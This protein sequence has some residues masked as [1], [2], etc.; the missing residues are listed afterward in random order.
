MRPD[1]A[2]TFPAVSAAA[3]RSATPG[4]APEGAAPERCF[5]L[6]PCPRCGEETVIAL[7]LDDLQAFRCGSCEGEFGREELEAIIARWT[8]V[9][10]WLDLAPAKE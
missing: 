6:L 3:V 9:L 5:G 2:E 7:D 4:T 10:R 8:P 1:Q